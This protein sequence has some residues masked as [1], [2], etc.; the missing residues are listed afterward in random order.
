MNQNRKPPSVATLDRAVKAMTAV[1]GAD[2]VFATAQDQDTYSDRF[3][4]DPKAHRPHAAVAPTTAEQVQAIVRIAGQYKVPLWPISRGKNL[5]YGTSAPVLA[6]SIVV[7][8]SRMTK[9]EVDVENG[10]V[11]LEPGVGFY[12]LYDYLQKN[13]IPLWLSVPGNAWGSVIGNALDRG[14]GYTPYGEHTRNLCGLEV[15]LPDGDLVRTGMG[16]MSN[17]P[18][19]NLH[20]YGFGPAWDQLFAQSNYG[21]VTKAGMWLMPAPECVLGFDVEMDRFEDLEPLIDTIGPLRREGILQQS[22]TIGNYFRAANILTTRKQWTD[23]P[24]SLSDEVI[25]AIRKQFNLGWWGVSVRVYGREAVAKANLD[26]VEKALKAI[27]PMSLKPSAWRTGEP[28]SPTQGGWMG[29]P[30]TFPMQ[31]ANWFGGRGGHIGFSP[32][33]PQ[34]GRLCMEQCRR[35]YARYKEYGMDYQASWAFGERHILNVNSVLLNLD[36]VAFMAKVDPFLRTLISDAAKYGYGEYRAHV[37]YMDT[38]A[39]VYDFN[40]NALRRLGERVKDAL[41]PAGIIAPGKS[42]IWPKAYRS[43]KEGK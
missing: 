40:N 30:M 38:V 33:L 35:A 18:T 2:A 43:G 7:D 15:V 39:D 26:I 28:F 9:I 8:L 23:Q 3:P 17:A 37:G 10:T 14:L 34:S 36:D 21:I 25:A 13:K 11:L 20:K 16:A 41:D 12:D 5:G 31:N 6:G 27:N 29:A 22:P 42:G 19:W 1:L 32:V 24:G 4:V